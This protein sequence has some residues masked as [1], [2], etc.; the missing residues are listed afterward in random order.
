MRPTESRTL[1]G[2]GVNIRDYGALGDVVGRVYEV[3]YSLG[4]VLV[5]QVGATRGS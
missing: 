3:S 1:T 4:A 2:R 5:C